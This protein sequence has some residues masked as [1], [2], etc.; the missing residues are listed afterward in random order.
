MKFFYSPVKLL[1]L[2]KNKEKYV[3]K[4]EIRNA[5][6]YLSG[7][8]ENAYAHADTIAKKIAFFNGYLTEKTNKKET[9]GGCLGAIFSSGK[10]KKPDNDIMKMSLFLATGVAGSTLSYSAYPDILDESKNPMLQAFVKNGVFN[11]CSL[12]AALKGE[13]EEAF[14]DAS[15]APYRRITYCNRGDTTELYRLER[16]IIA[17]GESDND[18]KLVA[19]YLHDFNSMEVK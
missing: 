2:I 18:C 13:G 11:T 4:E 10:G 5:E 16:L 8:G 6:W 15:N 14:S 9:N 19:P 3:I 1:S 17:I 7:N 12:L